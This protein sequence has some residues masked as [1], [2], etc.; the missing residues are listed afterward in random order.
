MWN[1]AQY[2]VRH[3]V[4]KVSHLFSEHLTTQPN[5]KLLVTCGN[6]LEKLAVNQLVNKFSAIYELHIQIT[7]MHSIMMFRLT[8]DRIYDGGPIRL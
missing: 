1:T 5:N 8:T 3:A 2:G 7:V 6:V 4:R